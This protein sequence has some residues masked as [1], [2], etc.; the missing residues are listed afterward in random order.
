MSAGGR[1]QVPQS[2]CCKIVV[3]AVS[4][5]SAIGGVSD[6]ADVVGSEHGAAVDVAVARHSHGLVIENVLDGA[7]SVAVATA[8]TLD[9]GA[10]IAQVLD[11]HAIHVLLIVVGVGV[12]VH[13]QS[14]KRGVG[15]VA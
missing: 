6:R 15:R 10:V 13:V 8:D 11:A 9:A 2:L 14:R 1:L 5:R 3:L 12:H 7:S 4:G